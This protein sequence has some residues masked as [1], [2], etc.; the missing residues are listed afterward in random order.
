MDVPQ[1]FVGL[2]PVSHVG[3]RFQLSMEQWGALVSCMQ[4]LLADEDL[5][6]HQEMD[7]ATA[8]SGSHDIREALADGSCR[9]FFIGQLREES[10]SSSVV[11]LELDVQLHVK[12]LDQYAAFLRDCGGCRWD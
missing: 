10:G 1:V 2:A 3:R 7:A 12:L 4:A 5:V 11:Q 9:R 6:F 8:L